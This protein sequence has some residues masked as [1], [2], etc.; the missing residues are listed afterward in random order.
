MKTSLFKFVAFISLFGTFATYA[1]SDSTRINN[2]RLKW[3]IG[4]SAVAYTGSLI[5]LNELWYNDFPKE[6]FHFFD[7]SKEWK[8][9]DKA[10]HLYSSYHISRTGYQALK[11]SGIDQRK[12]YIYGG[13]IG[14]LFM[15]PIEIMDGY[16]AEYGASTSDILANITGAT[17]FTMQGLVWNEIRIHPKYSFNRSNLAQLRPNI[18]GKTLSEELLKDYN[19]HIFWFSAD[20]HAFNKKIPKWLNLA[21]GY[22]AQNMIYAND[23]SNKANGFDSYR[24]YYLA[25]DFDLSH[26]QSKSWVI[27]TLLFVGDMIHLPA[28]TLEYNSKNKVK[29]HWLTY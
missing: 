9:V 29:F 27:N 8:Q 5:A 7:D 26:I 16:S 24:Q 23:Q 19:A 14:V 15:T 11:W 13:L 17:L 22:G 20:L 28:P 4:S 12:S 21:V 18:L 2:N 10:G 3:L 25:V 1:Q 6:G